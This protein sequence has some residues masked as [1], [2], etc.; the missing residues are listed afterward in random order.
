MPLLEANSPAFLNFFEGL[1]SRKGDE[2]SSQ[3]T[4]K[5]LP[6]ADSKIDYLEY[7]SPA[8]EAPQQ[9]PAELERPQPTEEY[10]TSSRACF[11]RKGARVRD[12]ILPTL[13][14]LIEA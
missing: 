13:Y 14:V 9:Q 7:P 10:A 12:M 8:T 4:P 3:T 2:P 5:R 11:S 1:Q 6:H